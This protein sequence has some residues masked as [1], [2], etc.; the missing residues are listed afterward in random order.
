MG[1]QF[2]FEVVFI[3]YFAGFIPLLAG[4]VVGD[5]VRLRLTGYQT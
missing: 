5:V 1:F 2:V 3:G 4:V